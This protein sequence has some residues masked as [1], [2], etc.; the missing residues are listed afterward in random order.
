MNEVNVSIIIAPVIEVYH[1][2]RTHLCECHFRDGSLLPE[3][4]SSPSTIKVTG[5]GPDLI[6]LSPFSLP[7]GYSHTFLLSLVPFQWL[8]K[9][10]LRKS[11]PGKEQE[12]GLASGCAELAP[13]GSWEIKHAFL[14]P[15]CTVTSHG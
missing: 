8:G 6:K 11:M 5:L 4:K 10:G 13:T 3:L 14:P 12:R 2:L 1:L 15:S 9:T 7:C